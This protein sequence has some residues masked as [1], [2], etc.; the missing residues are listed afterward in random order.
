MKL[1]YCLLVLL[2]SLTVNIYAKPAEMLAESYNE[3]TE[4]ELE[5][6]DESLSES[7]KAYKEKHHN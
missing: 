5:E 4:E 2:M 1:L 6:D 3:D 7:E